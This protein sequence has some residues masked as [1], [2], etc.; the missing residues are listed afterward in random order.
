MVAGVRWPWRRRLPP[1]QA[2]NE[3]PSRTTENCLENGCGDLITSS[4]FAT[5]GCDITEAANSAANTTS[6]I[7]FLKT[8]PLFSVTK[9]QFTGPLRRFRYI[10]RNDQL[11]G[12]SFGNMH[13]TVAARF[14]LFSVPGTD[15]RTATFKGANP[16][17]FLGEGNRPI[18]DPLAITITQ[19]EHSPHLGEPR[20]AQRTPVPPLSA[21]LQ[22]QAQQILRCHGIL[23]EHRQLRPIL[24][25][26]TRGT[27]TSR[28][29]HTHQQHTPPRPR[30]KAAMNPSVHHAAIQPHHTTSQK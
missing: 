10:Q 12:F 18:K 28:H 6:R 23:Q 16:A 5:A 17:R 7:N 9:N 25:Q 2:E 11:I 30:N 8:P 13:I 29:P 20:L 1:A 19:G 3:S 27:A 26:I 15:T 14:R 21:L 4:A 24:H 22:G